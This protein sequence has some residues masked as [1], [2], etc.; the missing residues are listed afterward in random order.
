MFFFRLFSIIDYKILNLVP[1]AIQYILA[2]YL[3]YRIIAC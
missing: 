3:F 1:C 2:V